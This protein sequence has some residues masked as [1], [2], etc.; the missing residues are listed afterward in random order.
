MR[1]VNKIMLIVDNKGEIVHIIQAT[2]YAE[3]LQPIRGRQVQDLFQIKQPGTL[4]QTVKAQTL[5]HLDRSLSEYPTLEKGFYFFEQMTS[6]DSRNRFETRVEGFDFNLSLPKSTIRFLKIMDGFFLGLVHLPLE[7][8]QMF[9]HKQDINLL[10]DKEEK[11]AGHDKRFD[12]EVGDD[13]NY[14]GKSLHSFLKIDLKKP[15]PLSLADRNHPDIIFDLK[16]RDARASLTFS[17]DSFFKTTG[18]GLSCNTMDSKEP[19]FV[20]LPVKMDPMA[21]D[22]VLEIHCGKIGHEPPFC[23]LH[24]SRLRGGAFPDTHGLFFGCLQ[25]KF[26]L[27]KFGIVVSDFNGYTMEE[28]ASE[29]EL[30]YTIANRKNVFEF[31][32]NRKIIGHYVFEDMPKLDTHRHIV[33][34]MRENQSCLFKKIQVKRFPSKEIDVQNARVVAY[35]KNNPD[36]LFNVQTQFFPVKGP[37]EK[38]IMLRHLQLEDLEVR[39]Q[40]RRLSMEKTA[41]DAEI[42]RLKKGLDATRKGLDRLIGISPAMQAV[43]HKLRSVSQSNATVLLTGNTGTGKNLAAGALHEAGPRHNRP[44]IHLDCAA[45]PPSLIESELFGVEKGAFTGANRSFPGKFEQ[46]DT[47][48]IFIDE[49]ANIPPDIQPKLLNVIQERTIQRIGSTRSKSVDIRII[50]ATNQDLTTLV[51]KGRFREDLY[52]RINVV[53]VDLPPLRSRPEDIPGLCEFILKRETHAHSVHSISP[54]VIKRLM[55]YPWPGNVRELYN[56]LLRSLVLCTSST[57]QPGDLE[58]LTTDTDSAEEPAAVKGGARWKRQVPVQ[59]MI[60]EIKACDGNVRWAASNLH[61][62]RYTIYKKLK[63]AGVDIKD[64]RQA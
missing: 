29:S 55:R 58:P 47:G 44:F 53:T 43:R 35:F 15:E 26:M 11:L 38:V 24:G 17:R 16:D 37:D 30:I 54:G 33:I 49:I 18:Q 63:A 36:R 40:I 46:A 22:H 41:R 3:D 57:L 10:I 32:I 61:V 62:A 28:A 19:A 59:R 8:R 50:A 14:L 31:S 9:A 4:E 52:Y 60:D 56:T 5:E 48:T 2:P 25:F 39:E 7:Y 21:F 6:Y 27:K 45:L 23:I 51:R 64:L 12:R 34:G 1:H 42:L 20:Q 13:R